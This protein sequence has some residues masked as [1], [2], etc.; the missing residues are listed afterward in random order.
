[1]KFSFKDLNYPDE[2]HFKKIIG[3]S[4]L[5]FEKPSNLSDA[6]QKSIC[7]IKNKDIIFVFIK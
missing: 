7:W 5:I 1:M 3:P 4:D 6:D 2:F